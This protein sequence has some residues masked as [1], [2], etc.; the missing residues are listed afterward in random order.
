MTVF[1]KSATGS[2]SGRNVQVGYLSP[3]FGST[4]ELIDGLELPNLS[5]SDIPIYRVNKLLTEYFHQHKTTSPS[6]RIA[7][8]PLGLFREFLLWETRDVLFYICL[9]AF[10]V[11]TLTGYAFVASMSL[12]TILL[13]VILPSKATQAL[14]GWE[15][16]KF[17]CIFLGTNHVLACYG[18]VCCLMGHEFITGSDVQ[19]AT[20]AWAFILYPVSAIGITAGPH[21]LWAH[22]SY[23]AATP[24]RVLLMLMYTSR[25][26]A[27]SSIGPAITARTIA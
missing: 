14:Q 23:Q 17:N 6:P 7:A 11:L 8:T 26:R 15:M 25:S 5:M 22:K 10:A 13:L 1:K 4:L 27:P 3:H 16:N 18:A 19:R 2:Y 21:R 9:G 20:I 24:M 12:M